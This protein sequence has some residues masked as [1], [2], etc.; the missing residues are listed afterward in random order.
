VPLNVSATIAADGSSC[1][2]LREG[3]GVKYAESFPDQAICLQKRDE[4]RNPEGFSCRA[5]H[6]NF[7][8]LWL[9]RATRFWLVNRQ[10]TLTVA[11]VR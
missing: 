3:T 1:A 5:S 4:P 2:T 9:R 6:G 10:I 7:V 8:W 11:T